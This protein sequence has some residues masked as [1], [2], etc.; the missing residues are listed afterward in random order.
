VNYTCL[1]SAQP[2]CDETG[3]TIIAR[4]TVG[5]DPDQADPGSALVMAAIPQNAG[6][7]NGGQLQFEPFPIPGDGRTILYIGMGDGG[8]SNDPNQNAQNLNSLLGKMLR[9]DVDDPGLNLPRYHIPTDNPLIDG[10]IDEIWAYGVRNPWRFS[11]DRQTGDLFIADVGQGAREEI[12]FQAVTSAGGEN[13]GWRQ[14]E[15]TRVNF[16]AEAPPE[17]F[18]C[19]GGDG[20]TPPILEYTHADGCSVT[21]GYIYRGVEFVPE[22][23]GTYF[24][25]DYCTG[26]LWGARQDGGGDWTTPIDQDTDITFDITTFGE[27]HDG[28]LYLATKSGGLYRI[29]PPAP[30]D[31]DL[32]VTAVDGP[33]HGY[34]GD[35]I[36]VASTTVQNQS[37][38]SA[39]ANRVGYYFSTDPVSQ[40][41]QTFSGSECSLPS[42]AGGAV[43]TCNDIMVNVP[44]SLSA[45]SY[46]LVAIVDDED[47]ITESNENNNDLADPQAIELIDCSD[48]GPEICFDGID[49][50]CDGL[51]DD[52][53]LD[54]QL[55]CFPQGASCDIDADCCS[56]KCRGGNNR[57]CKG[58]AACSPTE[59]PE[60]S[61]NDGQDNDCDGLTDIND[62]DCQAACEPTEDPEV[63]CSDGQDNDCDGLVDTDDPDCPLSCQ[64]KGAACT[65]NDD[66]C[67]NKCRGP[68]GRKSCK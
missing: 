59:N 6:N 40:P 12:D 20:L 11:F 39:G 55:A 36:D 54:C 63:S 46:S 56:L 50:D 41:D 22:L 35:V 66:C 47:I 1:A 34:I 48:P 51:V 23:G 37:T 17:P 49:N 52:D 9:V 30:P 45:G 7:H 14:C 64:P 16:P 42:L 68:D 29:R 21:G 2:D 58:E 8:G 57:T 62:P 61:C 15:G 60:V 4:Y 5:A 53:D 31:P 18:L 26:R 19:D 33:T 27:S 38:V 24:Y 28:E 43:Y 10:V 44:G 67:S 32:T 3:D 25:A 65:A 13:Y